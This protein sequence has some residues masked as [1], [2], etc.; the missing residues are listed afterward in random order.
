MLQKKPLRSLCIPDLPHPLAKGVGRHSHVVQLLLRLDYNNY[1][2]GAEAVVPYW[3]NIRV[4]LGLYG[5][6]GKAKRSCYDGSR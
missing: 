4:I 5:D 2:S 1:F 6:N 3:A